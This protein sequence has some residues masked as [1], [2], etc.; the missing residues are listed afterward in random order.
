MAANQTV[1]TL[2]DETQHFKTLRTAKIQFGSFDPIEVVLCH[3]TQQHGGNSYNKEEAI[4]N[5]D[6]GWN[7]VTHKKK[8]ATSAKHPKAKKPKPS[9]KKIK[10]RIQQRKRKVKKSTFNLPEDVRVQKPHTPFTLWDFFLESIRNSSLLT[11]SCNTVSVDVEETENSEPE[12]PLASKHTPIKLGSLTCVN[13]CLAC[14]GTIT[15]SDEDLLLS[16]TPYNRPLFVTGCVCE[17]RVNRILLDG[18]SAVNIMPL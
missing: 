8:S 13:N 5:D 7:L 15:L 14:I 9:P 10:T 3:S 16:A 11:L 1:A 2:L 17:Q 4:E 18:G 6:E 12:S